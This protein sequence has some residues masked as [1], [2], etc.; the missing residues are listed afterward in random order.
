MTA[1]ATNSRVSP[2]ADRRLLLSAIAK[3]ATRKKIIDRIAK[4]QNTILKAEISL[5]SS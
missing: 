4:I 5:K 3:L 2:A 1:A